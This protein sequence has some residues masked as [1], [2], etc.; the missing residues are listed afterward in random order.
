MGSTDNWILFSKHPKINATCF[1]GLNKPDRVEKEQTRRRARLFLQEATMKTWC[2][3]SRRG[4]CDCDDVIRMRF[5]PQL[6][7]SDVY[8]C[9]LMCCD[10]PDEA[11]MV[12][13]FSMLLSV[14]CL[15]PADLLVARRRK[16]CKRFC[17]HKRA[18]DH[19]IYVVLQRYIFGL[20]CL[21]LNTAYLDVANG[22]MTAKNS[23]ER[24]GTL[25]TW[26]N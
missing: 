10:V 12:S 5:Q 2:V 9:G 15:R 24:A 17:Q 23:Q 8:W 21:F 14:L 25:R 11:A 22:V 4:N 16:L 20:S 1:S 3:N 7:Y 13:M 6:P 18:F 26:R 19:S